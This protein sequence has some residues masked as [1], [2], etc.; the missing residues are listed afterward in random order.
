MK[1]SELI[2]VLN[3]LDPEE[4]IILFQSPYGNCSIH[5][6]GLYDSKGKDASLEEFILRDELDQKIQMIMK[7]VNV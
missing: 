2:N 5:L 1:I 6:P 7:K 3:S 4:N